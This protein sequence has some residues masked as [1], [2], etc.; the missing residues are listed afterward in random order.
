MLRDEGL[1]KKGFKQS[2]NAVNKAKFQC[3]T[4]ALCLEGGAHSW[5][6]HSRQSLIQCFTFILALAIVDML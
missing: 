6:V 1:S 2:S 3:L 4:K 5:T